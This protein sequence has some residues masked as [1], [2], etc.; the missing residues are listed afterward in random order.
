MDSEHIDALLEKYWKSETSVEEEKELQAL[1]IEKP[2]PD[3]LKE[4]AALFRYF[5]R[6][7]RKS[8]TDISFDRDVIRKIQAPAMG[9]VR[10]LL[11]NTMRIA[12]GVVVLIVAIWL[13]R[14]EVREITPAQTTDTYDDPEMAFEETKKA[15][16]MISKSFSTAEQQAKKINLFNEAQ[17]EIQKEETAAEL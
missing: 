15:L 9:K 7:K 4:T 8:L 2:V 17:Q 14:M 1:L 5:D 13:V 16:M 10:A 6:Q 12:A 11:F 3:H